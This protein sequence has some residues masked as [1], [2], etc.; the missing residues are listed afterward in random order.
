MIEAGER[1]RDA[2]HAM[3][4][5]MILG[6]FIRL[7]LYVEPDVD[8]NGNYLDTMNV[9]LPSIEGVIEQEIRVKI[10]VVDWEEV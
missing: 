3:V 6:E 2:N 7:G 9:L 8:G 10:K 4:S 5:G 1:P